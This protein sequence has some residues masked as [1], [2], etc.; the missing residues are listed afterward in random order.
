MVG[1][2]CHA[3]VDARPKAHANDDFVY[4]LVHTIKLWELLNKREGSKRPLEDAFEAAQ[5]Y[6]KKDNARDIYK[7]TSKHY[8]PRKTIVSKAKIDAVELFNKHD[9]ESSD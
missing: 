9:W 3:W 6:F 2:A 8:K 1:E 5:K 4:H 7:A